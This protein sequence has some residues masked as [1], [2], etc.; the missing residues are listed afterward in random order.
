MCLIEIFFKT[1]WLRA[2]KIENGLKLPF[3]A[4]SKLFQNHKFPSDTT[5]DF[6][7][8]NFTHKVYKWFEKKIERF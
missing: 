5:K 3:L 1:R 8:P 2:Q 4:K 6:R 7:K